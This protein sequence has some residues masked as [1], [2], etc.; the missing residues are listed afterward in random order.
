MDNSTTAQCRYHRTH[1]GKWQCSGCDLTLCSDCKP[2]AD[3]LPHDVPCPLCRTAMVDLE[4][5][6][7]FWHHWR[8]ILRY[9]VERTAMVLIGAVALIQLLTPAGL[10]T[11]LTGLPVLALFLYYASVVFDRSAC[12]STDAPDIAQLTDRTRIDPRL[13]W[14]KTGFI[15]AGAIFAAGMSG[16][17]LVLGVALL[18][19][20]M[21]LPASLMA[22]AMAG[23]FKAAFDYPRLSMIARRLGM[24]YNLLAAT[25]FTVATAPALA[26]YLPGLLLP[27]FIHA[28]MLTLV[29]G[30]ACL[31]LAYAIGRVLYR[32]R[33]ELD[34]AAGIDPIDRPLPPKPAV[35]EPVQALADA[36]VQMA[37][38]RLDQ[39]RVTI[40]EALTRYP[41]N[42]E[43]NRR[44]EKLL[45][46]EGR[47]TELKNHVERVL[48][49]KVAD[50][51]IAGAVDHWQHHRESLDGWEPRIS[52]TR[53]R[54][55][56]EL[57]TRGDHR[58]AVRLLLT[59]PKT[60]PRY[61]RL[62]EACLDA[63]R[64][65]EEH[66]GD[67]A[68]AEPLRRFV[69]KRF[70]GRAAAWFE[71]HQLSAPGLQEQTG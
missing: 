25:A 54:M 30:W 49:R 52:A 36:R 57:E 21:V 27:S 19:A 62:P 32:H 53:H 43:L 50:G 28:A 33:R 37:E 22:V 42:R 67:H 39:T 16:S 61:S 41:R 48:H 34:F 69:Q 4:A 70:P 18:L 9:P 11:V 20:A 40:G 63:A 44:F 51:D 23:Q 29:Y 7:P 55:A 10:A 47:I 24:E 15:Y 65:L 68:G 60:D 6:P 8:E 2:L 3:K 46:G 26:L 38:Q 35:Y 71:K 12:G 17:P 1:P 59:L 5:G 14:V 66:F 58:T 13:E 31:S 64:M 56:L 45:A